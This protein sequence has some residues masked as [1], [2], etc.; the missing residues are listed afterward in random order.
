[1]RALII[2]PAEREKLQELDRRARA[3][4]VDAKAAV[5]DSPE[6]QRRSNQAQTI[7]LPVGFAVTLTYEHQPAG[8]F[9]H[10][11]VSVDR[12]RK[13]PTPEAVDMI[14][15]SLGMQPITHSARVWIETISPTL[16]AINL[17]QPA[18]SS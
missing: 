4:I 17:L 8:L 10:V 18:L 1:M 16:S 5:E 3:R 14:L 15:A 11:S 12:P 9:R 6:A 13:M 2:G 7:D